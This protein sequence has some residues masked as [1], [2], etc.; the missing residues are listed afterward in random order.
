M[1]ENIRN[2]HYRKLGPLDCLATPEELWEDRLRQV[3][4]HDHPKIR[5]KRER[6][7]LAVPFYE[8]GQGMQ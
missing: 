1:K 2:E 3:N 8:S 4:E 7:R 5:M 6:S